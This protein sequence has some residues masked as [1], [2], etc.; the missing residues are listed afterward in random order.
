MTREEIEAALGEPS[1]RAT[2]YKDGRLVGT[3]SDGTGSYALVSDGVST[4]YEEALDEQSAFRA[5]TRLAS[6]YLLHG[7][8]IF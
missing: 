1:L 6:R 7:K 4:L 2:H 3:I 5:T 8:E